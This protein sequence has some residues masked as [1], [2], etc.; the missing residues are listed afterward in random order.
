MSVKANY[1]NGRLRGKKT[2]DHNHYPQGKTG[3]VPDPC[4]DP[5]N[6]KMKWR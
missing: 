5:V 4:D 1:V 2:R 3:Y 6:L